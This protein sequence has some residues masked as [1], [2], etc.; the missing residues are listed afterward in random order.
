MVDSSTGTRRCVLSVRVDSVLS[1]P[2]MKCFLS[3]FVFV[4]TVRGQFDRDLY[5]LEYLASG[6]KHHVFT[7]GKDGES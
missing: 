1:V 3:L 4:A 7:F 2:E 5:S 6:A